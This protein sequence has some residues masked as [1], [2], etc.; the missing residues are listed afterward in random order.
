[1]IYITEEN[2]ANLCDILWW[3]KGYKK[4]SNDNLEECPFNEDHIKTLDDVVRGM[5]TDLNQVKVNPET[6]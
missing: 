2:R 3:L 6:A 1:M 4:G 5:R